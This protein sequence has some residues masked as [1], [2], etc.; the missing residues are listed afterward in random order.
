MADRIQ[1]MRMPLSDPVEMQELILE[2]CLRIGRNL[3]PEEWY[4]YFGA[5]RYRPTC[6]N[7][8]ESPS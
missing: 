3:T 4:E 6:P 2:V 7:V 5:E 8:P 1:A